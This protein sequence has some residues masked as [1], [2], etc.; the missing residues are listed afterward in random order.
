MANLLQSTL[1]R[2]G[3]PKSRALG[4][5]TLQLAIV[6][7]GY[8]IG[9]IV[10]TIES[11]CETRSRSGL[12]LSKFAARFSGR[13]RKSVP[14]KW[15]DRFSR[16]GPL[17]QHSVYEWCPNGRPLRN[18]MAERL[19]HYRDQ[20]CKTAVEAVANEICDL[21]PGDQQDDI[22]LILA[23]CRFHR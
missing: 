21:S 5:F 15:R 16:I 17:L 4:M 22:T 11:R 1:A 6:P 10:R 19:R 12:L 3:T 23:R 9:G 14:G 13:F 20:R 7:N 2:P 8:E 18:W